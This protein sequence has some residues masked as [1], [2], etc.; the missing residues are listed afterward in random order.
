MKAGRPPVRLSDLGD[1]L[2][3]RDLAALLQ[4]SPSFA[5]TR[6]ELAART[7]LTPNLPPALPGMGKMHRYLKEDVEVWL[8]T[9]SRARHGFRRVSA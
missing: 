4:M 8:R 1:V 7:G 9:G 3:D 5:R 6:R 2:S